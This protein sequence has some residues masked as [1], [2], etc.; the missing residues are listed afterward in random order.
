M[1]LECIEWRE[2][3]RKAE[4]EVKWREKVNNREQLESN[5]S[6]RTAEWYSLTPT[7]AKR[8]QEQVRR[9]ALTNI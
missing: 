2:D 8:K 7:K 5:E 6:S 3:I 4:E 9:N 1:G